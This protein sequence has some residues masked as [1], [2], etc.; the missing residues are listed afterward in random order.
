M[1]G[2]VSSASVGELVSGRVAV[3]ATQPVD[4]PVMA[5]GFLY[6][7]ALTTRLPAIARIG[8]MFFTPRI[9]AASV[10]SGTR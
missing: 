5:K 9:T 10:S 1:V 4:G 3:S 2:K 7:L 8:E 6:T